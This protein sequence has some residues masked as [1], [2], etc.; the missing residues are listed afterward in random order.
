MLANVPIDPSLP[1]RLPFPEAG[2]P[3]Q[4]GKPYTHTIAVSSLFVQKLSP[5]PTAREVWNIPPV[6]PPG[7][8]ESKPKKARLPFPEAGVPL[9]KGQPRSGFAG[10]KSKPYG[11]ESGSSATGSVASSASSFSSEGSR[12]GNS[13]R[14]RLVASSQMSMAR[15]FPAP[16][17]GTLHSELQRSGPHTGFDT[18]PMPFPE[19]GVPL[20]R[21]RPRGEIV[22]RQVQQRG[23]AQ[24]SRS[25]ASANAASSQNSF[26]S[27][28]SVGVGS[29]NGSSNTGL[30][31]SPNFKLPNC[32]STASIQMVLVPAVRHNVPFGVPTVDGLPNRAK[33]SQFGMFQTLGPV[34]MQSSL[35]PYSAYSG[36]IQIQCSPALPV[37][38]H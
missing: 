32:P 27:A 35:L 16:A 4:H 22:G 23:H 29:S 20:E 6:V 13:N 25:S 5:A 9:E 24:E 31:K 33:V 3:Q 8:S 30:R 34:R 38:V 21:G 12:T 28:R 7:D 14:S 19:A 1:Q 36:P 10:H 17:S 2:L 18:E 11:I 26:D 37:A 15:R